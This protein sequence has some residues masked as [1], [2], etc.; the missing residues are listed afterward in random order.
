MNVG[1]KLMPAEIGRTRDPLD[2]PAVQALAKMQADLKQLLRACGNP[3]FTNEATKRLFINPVLI[4]SV[5]NVR[6]VVERS[7]K[8]AIG[9]GL[10]DYV[11]DY[12]KRY[13]ILVT[14]AKRENV[15]AAI[16][17]CVAEM[18]AVSEVSPLCLMFELTLAELAPVSQ[19][20][21][22]IRHVRH[23]HRWSALDISQARPHWHG[24]LGGQGSPHGCRRRR[25]H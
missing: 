13:Y 17:Q 2:A 22:R 19:A 7:L 12:L 6:L 4:V 11:L 18:I 3:K 8:G 1:L 23:C 20:K 15:D 21:A 5:E 16:A 14:E 10:A 24:L 9:S 25:V